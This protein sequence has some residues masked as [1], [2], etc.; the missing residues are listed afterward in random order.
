MPWSWPVSKVPGGGPGAWFGVQYFHSRLAPG[1]RVTGPC[2]WT[3]L[4]T[5]FAPKVRFD[6]KI[7]SLMQKSLTYEYGKGGRKPAL[8]PYLDGP[9][10]DI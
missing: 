3:C 8:P 2:R 1:R 9:A 4:R 6:A 7:P 5:G 10:R